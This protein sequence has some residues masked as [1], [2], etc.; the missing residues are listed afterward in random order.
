MNSGKRMA[1]R[2]GSV[3][4][5][6]RKIYDPLY[7]GITG[8]YDTTKWLLYEDGNSFWGVTAW[9]DRFAGAAVY[10]TKEEAEAEAF[11]T[12]AEYPQFIG[13]L[14][15]VPTRER[16]KQDQVL[17]EIA[18]NER[19]ALRAR[20]VETV[21]WHRAHRAKVAEIDAQLARMGIKRVEVKRS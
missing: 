18:T 2:G 19:K 13:K 14:T 6:E 8:F 9:C 12:C 21:R 1:A 4:D 17:S 7:E 15:V 20:R 3:S 16:Y 11:I 5:K 10:D